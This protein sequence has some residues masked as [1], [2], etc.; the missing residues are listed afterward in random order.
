M[1]SYIVE[2][3]RLFHQIIGLSQFRLRRV[4]RLAKQLVAQAGYDYEIA[5]TKLLVVVVVVVVVVILSM[6]SLLIDVVH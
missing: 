6:K 2:L 1:I 3:L 5:Y 4:F